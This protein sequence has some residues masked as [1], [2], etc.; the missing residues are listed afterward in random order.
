[1]NKNIYLSKQEQMIFNIISSADIISNDE[2]KEAFPK[3]KTYQINKIC[4]NLSSK[5][6]LY[7]LKKGAYLVQKKASSIPVIKNPYEVAL[8]LFKGYIGFSSAL[9]VY[10]LI[11]YEPFT[12]FVITRKKSMEKRI[13]EYTF[14]SVAMGEKAVGIVHYRGVY[15]SSLPKTFF[16]CFYKPQYSGG[17]STI[18]KAL[19][20]VDLNWWEFI[21][22]FD[23][24]SAS[25]C[26]RTGYILEL[27]KEE[28]DKKIPKEV[29]H[30][31]RKRIKNNTKLLPSGK[32]RG[33]YMK[34]WMV[35]DNLGKENI[36][37]WWYHG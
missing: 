2:I 5:G 33:K 24:A 35:M 16:D 25:L 37:S 6:Y 12:I 13:G 26:Q 10:D 4:S 20:D 1:M 30:Y 29:L 11:D 15:I 34:E 19:Y 17:Y 9:R 21:K 27:L 23:S 8:A 36:L 18:T 7:Y 32:A 3:L 31:F 14:K 22:Y 28:T